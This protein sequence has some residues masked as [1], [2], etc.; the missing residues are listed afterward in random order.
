M[1]IE[2]DLPCARLTHVQRNP[3][4]LIE[5][6]TGRHRLNLRGRFFIWAQP[7]IPAKA[8]PATNEFSNSFFIRSKSKVVAAT[9]V[10]VGP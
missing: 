2:H 10:D 7:A 9:I 5:T 6:K 8:A 1:E 3:P 4:D